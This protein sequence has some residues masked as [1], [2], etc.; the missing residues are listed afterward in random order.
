MSQSQAV[1]SS[2]TRRETTFLSLAPVLHTDASLA[3]ISSVE[4][5][6]SLSA[7]A[8]MKEDKTRR[9]SSDAS[10]ESGHRFLKLGHIQPGDDSTAGD[11]A[12][13]E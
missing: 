7:L 5:T 1:G 13:E 10:A 6:D 2:S 12:V 11:F 4:S 8:T 9:S 3:T